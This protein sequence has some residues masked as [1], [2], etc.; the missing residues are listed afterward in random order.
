[1]SKERDA[2]LER[3]EAE[4]RRA[5]SEHRYAD[6]ADCHG[7]A[8][9]L[10]LSSGSP[11]RAEWHL[12]QAQQ[13]G[14]R[15]RQP[16]VT[17]RYTRLQGVLLQREGRIE[18]AR[19]LLTRAAGQARMADS[20]DDVL[21]A[22]DALIKLLDRLGDTTGALANTNHAIRYAVD[23]ERHAD[24]A[25]LLDMKA[26]F[27]ASLGQTD[28]AAHTLQQAVA[29]ATEAGDR[30][31]QLRMRFTLHQLER[32]HAR[33][34]SEAL[35][36]I[37]GDAA[38]VEG[39]DDVRWEGEL[40]QAAE[41]LKVGETDQAVARCRS[42]RDA[43]LQA[44]HLTTFLQAA[45][46]LADAHDQRD[47]RTLTLLTLLGAHRALANLLGDA[48]AEPVKAVMG[49][50]QQQWGAAAFAEAMQSLKEQAQRPTP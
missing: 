2:E 18:E 21:L 38:G 1:V 11:A 9:V 44:R 33:P 7:R 25:A 32:A 16:A 26:K 46:L 45:L 40:L 27:E 30:V 24:V 15:A 8:A 3:L 29:A 12:L 49:R 10:H 19:E 42:V 23:H 5:E 36:A 34:P 37:L 50:Y 6:V 14:K 48:A 43:S 13:A 47:E 39:L 20:V 17:S 28:R 4:A 41:H 22:E 31:L 35:E